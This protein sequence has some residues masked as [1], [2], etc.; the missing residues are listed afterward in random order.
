MIA[1]TTTT[2]GR[3]FTIRIYPS[4]LDKNSMESSSSASKGSNHS[5]SFIYGLGF[6]GALIYFIQA[7]TS[8]W[9]GVVAFFKAVFWPAFLVYYLLEF[10]KK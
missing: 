5:G 1:V 4:I 7:A 3:H 9:I 6:V 10:L 8:F 2:V